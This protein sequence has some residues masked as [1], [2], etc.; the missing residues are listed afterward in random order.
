M[1]VYANKSLSKISNIETG[2]NDNKHEA[3]L[4]KLDNTKAKEML[5]WHPLMRSED[6]TQMTIDW[7][8]EFYE[9]N[10]ISTGK[11]IKKFEKLLD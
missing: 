10:I 6:A 9:N 1:C 11:D 4:L 3:G 7:Y 8:R 2:S 5:N